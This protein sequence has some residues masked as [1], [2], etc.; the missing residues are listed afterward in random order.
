MHCACAGGVAL[1]SV[2]TSRPLT[3]KKIVLA[4]RNSLLPEMQS[5]SD[6]HA[7]DGDVY[8]GFSNIQTRGGPMR[9]HLELP[10]SICSEALPI[11]L[12]PRTQ[13]QKNPRGGTISKRPEV[14]GQS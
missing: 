2:E 10:S 9:F 6:V 12:A 5:S 7:A 4:P 8:L 13:V 14:K 1:A 3:G 11:L